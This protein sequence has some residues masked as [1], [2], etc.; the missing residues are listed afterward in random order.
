M[1]RTSI[2]LYDIII[3]FKHS[4]MNCMGKSQYSLDLFS[5]LNARSS[6]ILY[7]LYTD[8]LLDIF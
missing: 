5:I 2:C 4:I 3:V 7:E 1:L 6:C 8:F